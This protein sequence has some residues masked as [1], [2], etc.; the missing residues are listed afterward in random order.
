VFTAVIVFAAGLIPGLA[1][2]LLSW[3]I[4]CIYWGGMNLFVI[5]SLAEVFILFALK[6]KNQQQT[7]KTILFYAGIIIGLLLCYIICV[8]TVSILGGIIH[9]VSAF[10]SDL[11]LLYSPNPVDNFKL[12]F[13]MFDVSKLAV[14]ILSRIPV[15]IVDRF[16]V[17]F[18]GYGIALG[19]RK[20]KI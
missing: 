13:V 20:L 5:C 18:G 3:V 15:N 17:I 10:F 6:P 7:D 16:I 19:L 9:Y 2:A 8:L 4:T 12:N 1:V 11:H 14:N